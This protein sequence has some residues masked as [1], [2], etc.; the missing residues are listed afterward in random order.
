MSEIIFVFHSVSRFMTGEDADEVLPSQ[1]TAGA[2]R[3][4]LAAVKA[5]L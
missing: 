4:R 3:L 2:A 5:C 1:R